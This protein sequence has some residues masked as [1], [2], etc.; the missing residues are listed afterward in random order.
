IQTIAIT[1][2]IPVHLGP[3]KAVCASAP[4]TLNAGAGYDQ[5]LWHDSSTAQ[6][7]T[8]TVPGIYWVTVKKGDCYSSDTVL[9]FPCP[10]GE[11]NLYIPNAFTPNGDNNNDVFFVV[12][13]DIINF[14]IIIYNRWGGAV[15][16]TKDKD[17]GW[18]GT[19]GGK[20]VP[21]GVY[22]YTISFSVTDNPD[23]V[24]ERKGSVLLLR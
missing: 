23:K 20:P 9:L 13:N 8:A 2:I 12:G 24:T 6:N 5:Y 18:D 17:L 7:Y 19:F 4:V 3:D 21:E 10:T 16:K 15:F 1:D 22:F 14:S 11:T